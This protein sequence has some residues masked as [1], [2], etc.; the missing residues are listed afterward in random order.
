MSAAS[1]LYTPQVLALATALADHPLIDQLERRGS[2]RSPVCGSTLEIGIALEASGQIAATGMRVSACAIGQAA[3]A[4][5][6]QSANG[7]S[8]SG[9]ESALDQIEAWLRRERAEMPDWPGLDAIAGAIDYPARH[10]AIVLPWKAALA[11]LP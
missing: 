1:K 7:A 3:A 11:A 8:R 10:G 2:A 9:I 4:L 5:F 6:A